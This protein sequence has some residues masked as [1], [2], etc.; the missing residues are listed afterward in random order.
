V[1]LTGNTSLAS[2]TALINRAD[3]VI[4]NDSGAMHLATALGVKTI[5]IFGPTEPQRFGPYPLNGP[6]NHVIQAPLGD[7]RLLAAK[8]VLVRFR[9]LEAASR[10]GTYHSIAPFAR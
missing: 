5:G 2:L 9:R 4:S 1:N 8:D 7:L 6:T 3:W 10:G